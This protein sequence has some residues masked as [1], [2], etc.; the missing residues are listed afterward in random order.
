M[1]DVASMITSI[2]R[3]AARGGPY[4]SGAGQASDQNAAATDVAA[5][6]SHRHTFKIPS[7]LPDEVAER[8][9]QQV[10]RYAKVRFE[11]RV[12]LWLVESVVRIRQRIV[13][14]RAVQYRKDA[15]AHFSSRR[16]R[17]SAVMSF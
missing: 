8:G 16:A 2:R 5:W 6:R 15:R 13:V 12:V 11:Q 4:Q 3:S 7:I 14:A 1:T 17:P 10:V 9:Q